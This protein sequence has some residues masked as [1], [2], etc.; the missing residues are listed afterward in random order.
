MKKIYYLSTCDTCKRI[1]NDLEL[2]EKGF[3]FQDIKTEKITAQQLTKL[4]E[5]AGSYVALFS[6]VAR[7]YKELNLASKQLTEED[8]KQHLLNEYTFLKRP[9]ILYKNNIF[10]GNSKAVVNEIKAII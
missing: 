2:K 7:K 10:I 6:K 1:I 8:Y 3:E 4:H 5:L 9:V